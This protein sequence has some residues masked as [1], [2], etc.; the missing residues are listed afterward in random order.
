DCYGDATGRL[1]ITVTGGRAPFTYAWTGPNGYTNTSKNISGLSAGDYN[2]TVTD[3]KGCSSIYAPLDS[4]TEPLQLT[5]SLARNDITCFGDADGSVTITASGGTTPYEYS[6]N[7]V[8]WQSSNIFDPMNPGIYTFET[9]DANSCTVSQQDTIIQSQEIIITNEE[10]DN[11]GQRCNGDSNGMIIIT[12]TGGTGLL[13][14]SI[15]GGSIY[16]LNNIFVGL[17]SGEYHVFLRDANACTVEG[18]KPLIQNP[19]LLYIDTLVQ[20]D[21]T[22]CF[23]SPEGLILIEG[24][25]GSPPMTYIRNAVDT[26]STG[27]FEN[28]SQGPHDLQILDTKGCTKDTSVAINAPP[29][30][31]TSLGVTHVATCYEDSSGVIAVIASGGTGLAKGYLFQGD[32]TFSADTVFYDSLLVG[33]YDFTVIDSLGCEVDTSAMV[34]AP[35]SIAT[36]SVIVMPV[37]CFGDTDGEIRVYGSGGTPPYTYILSPGTDTSTTGIYTNLAAGDYTVN[38]G[39]SQG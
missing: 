29:P 39:D 10:T 38:V 25:G 3:V 6:K 19:P 18:G 37:T 32:T 9:R 16:Q 17:G 12:A 26:N 27:L 31:T 2:L 34:N 36:D 4:I 20:Q 22:S 1:N 11:S 28:L 14:Y 8:I 30:I 33:N 24:A 15:D 35:D 13:E 21:I 23:G 5:M 7:G